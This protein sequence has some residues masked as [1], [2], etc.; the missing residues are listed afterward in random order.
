MGALVLLTV[1]IM[2]MPAFGR[3]DVVASPLI[4]MLIVP[5]GRRFG[6]AAFLAIAR[7]WRSS[8][9]IGRLPSVRD[10]SITFLPG[11]LRCAVAGVF[12]HFPVTTMLLKPDVVLRSELVSERANRR[13]THIGRMLAPPRRCAF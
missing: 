10:R 1:F 11:I 3:R 2:A 4:A 7:P 6:V 13:N 12:A 8:E 5:H 9:C